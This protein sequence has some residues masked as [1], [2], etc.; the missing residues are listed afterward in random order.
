[1]STPSSTNAISPAGSS[2][3]DLADVS[4]A[5]SA[6]FPAAGNDLLDEIVDP[7]RQE[8]IHLSIRPDT[9]TATRSQRH[10][11]ATPPED[12]DAISSVS[13]TTAVPS[14][15]RSDLGTR[16]QTRARGTEE[17]LSRYCVEMG[18]RILVHA[19]HFIMA[20]VFEL[21]QLCSDLKADA[22]SERGAV[23]A[24]QGQLLETRREAADLHRR[25]ILAEARTTTQP[26]P[27]TAYSPVAMASSQ[28]RPGLPAG[29]HAG[30]LPGSAIPRAALTYA[31]AFQAGAA[32]TAT[33]STPDGLA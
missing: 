7:N 2:S 9:A 12:E 22:A 16:V 5:S 21:V 1:M 15:L 6:A 3:P 4:G 18:N 23:M 30:L 28:P 26:L 14:A 11:P 29:P 8:G 24:L 31:A 33:P 25:A 17:E 20:H 27:D 32:A 19:R 10:I 13:Q